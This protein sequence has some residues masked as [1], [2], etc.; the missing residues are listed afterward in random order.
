MLSVIYFRNPFPSPILKPEDYTNQLIF[1]LV[2]HGYGTC[3]LVLREGQRRM[4]L[5]NKV[6][7]R[8]SGRKREEIMRL[9]GKCHNGSFTVC[10]RHETVFVFW[11][12]NQ[13]L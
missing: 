10:I 2:L 1:P 6:M 3:S 11:R 7:S 5:E 9:W 13:G 4:V 12:S 8:I